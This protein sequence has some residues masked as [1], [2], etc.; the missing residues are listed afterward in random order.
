M[1]KTGGLACLQQELIKSPLCFIQRFFHPLHGL[2]TRDQNP[3]QSISSY[4]VTERVA[5]GPG[6]KP[7]PTQATGSPIIVESRCRICLGKGL[8]FCHSVEV[9]SATHKSTFFCRISQKSGEVSNARESRKAI[10][11][12]IEPLSFII[13]ERVFLEMPRISA[14]S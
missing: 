10:S 9:C 13:L 4:F 11:G 5:E 2:Q 14:I 6:S 3:Y 1:R 7:G 12:V 8:T